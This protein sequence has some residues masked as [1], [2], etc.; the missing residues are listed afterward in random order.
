[1]RGS[2]EAF[3]ELWGCSNLDFGDVKRESHTLAVAAWTY[4]GARLVSPENLSM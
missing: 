4:G 3:S 1:L 2:T